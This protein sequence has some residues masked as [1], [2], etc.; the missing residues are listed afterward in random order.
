M[1]VIFD[2]VLD[3]ISEPATANNSSNSM[4]GAVENASAFQS[5]DDFSNL[6]DIMTAGFK[7]YSFY[8]YRS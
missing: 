3:G 1:A 4:L 6:A 8:K 2:S 7:K 5:V